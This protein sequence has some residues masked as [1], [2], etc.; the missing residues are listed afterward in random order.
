MDGANNSNIGKISSRPTSISNDNSSFEAGENAEKFPVGP[1]M[2]K[3]GPIL[4]IHALK[5][6]NVEIKSKPS[7]DNSKYDATKIMRYTAINVWTP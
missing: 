1:T 5:A 3:P 7:S 6:V 4:L 2:P